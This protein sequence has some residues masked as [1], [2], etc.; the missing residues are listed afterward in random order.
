MPFTPT[1][2]GAVSVGVIAFRED[3]TASQPA[4]IALSVVGATSES[5]EPA[6]E[7][8]AS[9]S[10]ESE[11]SSSD[12]E[13]SSSSSSSGSGGSVTGTATELTNIRVRPGPG[14]EIVGQVQSGETVTFLER[15]TW[16]PH[17]YRIDEGWV[18][19][20]PF[21]VGDDSDVPRVNE[22]G[23]LYCGDGICS[24]EIGEVCDECTE[25]CGVCPFCGDGEVNQP[26]EECDGDSSVCGDGY[27]C[28]A[29]CGCVLEEEEEPPAPTCGD[30]NVDPGEEC[31]G[32]GCGIGEFCNDS[33]Q[34]GPLVIAPVAECGNGVVEVGE[35]CDPPGICTT[36]GE[37]V[38]NIACQY[39][40]CP[41]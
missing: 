41:G 25:D 33:C 38:C 23:C 5:P 20:E 35:D 8:S 22:Q 29:S 34:C 6:N 37:Q 31:D 16:E 27:T 2:E 19:N 18:Y 17:W 26:S 39:S 30:G 9:E 24:E 1:A 11:S 15:T 14:C 32:G 7:E 40:T 36:P 10:A 4:V 12:S 13:S 21:T 3:G 28:T